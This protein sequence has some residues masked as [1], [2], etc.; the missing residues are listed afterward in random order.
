MSHV[1]SKFTIAII[2]I[3]DRYLSTNCNSGICIKN[4]YFHTIVDFIQ[5]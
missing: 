5:D 4:L 3:G 1:F 2:K